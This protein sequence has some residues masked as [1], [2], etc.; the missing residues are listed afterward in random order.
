[1]VAMVLLCKGSKINVEARRECLQRTK[2]R[3]SK[4]LMKV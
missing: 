1:M 4:L 2:E 3:Q